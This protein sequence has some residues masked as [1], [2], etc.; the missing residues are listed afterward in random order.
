MNKYHPEYIL[1]ALIE[2]PSLLLETLV[3]SVHT[4]IVEEQKVLT[5]GE[6]DEEEIAWEK[7]Q[8]IIT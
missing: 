3:E 2:F 5:E 4:I 8:G 1:E 7:E 6:F